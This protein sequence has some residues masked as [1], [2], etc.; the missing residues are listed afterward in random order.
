MIK[1]DYQQQEEV[2]HYEHK[3]FGAVLFVLILLTALHPTWAKP[4]QRPPFM[5]LSLAGVQIGDTRSKYDPK[6][7]YFVIGTGD[8]DGAHMSLILTPDLKAEGY[9]WEDEELR[10]LPRVSLPRLRTGKGVNI[11]ETPS[12][13]QRKLGAAPHFYS[14]DREKKELVYVYRA[15]YFQRSGTARAEK[16]NCTGSYKFRNGRLWSIRYSLN[17]ADGCG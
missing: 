11:G 5:R 14:Y 9:I 4:S 3:Y 17:E 15:S 1:M 8:C 2:M 6:E 12:Q 7:R 16:I 10:K 13:V